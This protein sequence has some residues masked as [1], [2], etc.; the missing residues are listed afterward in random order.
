MNSRY[1]LFSL[2]WLS[3]VVLCNKPYQHIL[4]LVLCICWSP[5]NFQNGIDI[6]CMSCDTYVE[7]RGQLAQLVLPFYHVYL[8]DGTQVIRL[9]GRSLDL[10]SYL[11][12]PDSWFYMLS[13]LYCNIFVFLRHITFPTKP[14]LSA[15][16]TLHLFFLYSSFPF[17][18]NKLVCLIIW[19]SSWLLLL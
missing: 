12:G 7:I 18:L 13:T 2:C 4:Y 17:G 3:S 9:G 16:G 1:R 8:G 19:V 11:T 10:L 15:T 6:Y 14:P 5:L